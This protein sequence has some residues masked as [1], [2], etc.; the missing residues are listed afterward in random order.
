MYHTD[1]REYHCSLGRFIQVDPIGLAAGPNV[2]AYCDGWP[3]GATDP[4]GLA[5]DW[6]AFTQA[7]WGAGQ[8]ATDFFSGMGAGSGLT[9]DSQEMVNGETSFLSG[10]LTAAE[11][12]TG[13]PVFGQL[14]DLVNTAGSI[15]S[16]GMMVMGAFRT[17]KSVKG[18]GA[19]KALPGKGGLGSGSSVRK[20]G[21]GNIRGNPV[22]NRSGT[23]VPNKPANLTPQGAGRSGAFRQAKADAGIPRSQ[24]PSAVRVVPDRTNPGKTVREYEFEVPGKKEPVVIREDRSGHVYGDESQSRGPHFNGPDGGHYDY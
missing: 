21:G 16:N 10:L 5:P 19:N 6:E 20:P 2:Y 15:A 14:R 13:N 3:T 4:S 23:N 8:G 18:V 1:A 9:R 12:L 22:Q 7:I 17:V 11:A 24:Q